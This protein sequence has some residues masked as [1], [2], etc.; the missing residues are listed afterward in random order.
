MSPESSTIGLIFS[1]RKFRLMNS[2]NKPSN[3]TILVTGGT[4]YI[5]SHTVVALIAAGYEPV[6]ID[7]LSNHGE[8]AAFL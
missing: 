1:Y 2:K 6:I 4:G 3:T 5:G 8:T 7:N